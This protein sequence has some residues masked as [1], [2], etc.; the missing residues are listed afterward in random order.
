MLRHIRVT[1]IGPA[2]EIALKPG[3]RTTLLTGDNGLGRRL[4]LD[5]AWRTLTGRWPAEANPELRTG[6]AAFARPDAEQ[7]QNRNRHREDDD[8]AADTRTARWRRSE[9]TSTSPA[10][11]CGRW[12]RFARRLTPETDFTTDEHRRNV[13]LTDR[14]V[15]GVEHVFDRGSLYDPE[16]LHLLI[17]LQTPCMPSASSTA[18][19]TT[20]CYTNVF[21]EGDRWI[22][23]V[24]EPRS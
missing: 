21:S 9:T 11:V 5:S 23:F 8:G 1:N 13:F 19:S 2:G 10:S 18:T 12:R 14:G 6:F 3:R 16:N 15:D 20:G 22:S 24:V 7:A 17:A 4:L